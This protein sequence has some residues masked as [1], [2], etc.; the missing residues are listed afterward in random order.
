MQRAE[1]RESREREF[2]PVL[3]GFA[4]GEGRNWLDLAL[5]QRELSGAKRK[6]KGLR[7]DF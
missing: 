1:E 5:C 7:W 3:G 2:F 6:E 4:W